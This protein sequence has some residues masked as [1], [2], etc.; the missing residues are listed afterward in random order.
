MKLLT[1]LLIPFVC[2]AFATAVTANPISG[3]LITEISTDPDWFEVSSDY[4]LPLNEYLLVCNSDTFYFEPDT[5]IGEGE[6][7]VFDTEYFPTL[8]FPEEGG[9]IKLMMWGE[10]VQVCA[11]GNQGSNPAPPAGATM[12]QRYMYWGWGNGEATLYFN[13]TPNGPNPLREPARGETDIIL[14]EIN[15]NSDWG[16]SDFIELYNMSYESI[17]LSGWTLAGNSVYTFPPGTEI[18]RY[19]TLREEQSPSFFES[20]DANCDNIYLFNDNSILVDQAGWSS[21]HG[22]NVSFMRYPDGDCHVFDGW[23]DFTSTDFEDGFPS[24][25]AFNRFDC[26]G[27]VVI[28]AEVFQQ[29]DAAVL[30]WTDP[31][32]NESF[33]VSELIRN[34]D[35]F[36]ADINDGELV[37]SGGDESFIDRDVEL[38][39]DYY[40]T[41][42]ARHLDGSYSIP[43]DESQA[44]VTIL[45]LAGIDDDEII[46][47][48]I[49]LY[50]NVPNPFN[51]TTTI[52]FGLEKSGVVKLTVYDILGR[53]V[54]TLVDGFTGAGV[55]HVQFDA[56]K[57]PSGVYF[58]KLNA[59][60]KV[61]TKRMTLLK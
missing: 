7:L 25:I 35:H 26:P 3:V 11:Y 49:T 23:S 16:S 44:M 15:I 46:P 5:V 58:Y 31:I 8:D 48:K 41:V 42:F 2:F 13:P 38:N 34:E 43:T 27:F 30:N 45:P 50:Q 20:L 51:A 14:N 40:Y 6:H 47:S 61:V 59:G 19:Y 33:Q 18:N 21:N 17:S 32:W 28:G 36:P 12:G 1:I 52:R 39:H 22:E 4:N 29:E 54:Q 56:S 10:T 60:D 24:K 9:I 57:H 55:H 53:E 37:Y